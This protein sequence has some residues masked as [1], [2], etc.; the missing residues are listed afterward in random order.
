M[1][2][3]RLDFLLVNR[4]SGAVTLK[5]PSPRWG[6]QPWRH[7]NSLSIHH[8]NSVGQRVKVMAPCY[9]T[10]FILSYLFI[11]NLISL[12]IT[13]FYFGFAYDNRCLDVIYFYI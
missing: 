10:V 11:L 12:N 6:G 4:S 1:L 7:L 13:L 9:L 2:R 8:L 5:G 3:N